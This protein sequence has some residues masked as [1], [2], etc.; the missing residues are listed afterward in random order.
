MPGYTYFHAFQIKIRSRSVLSTGI[1]IVNA[2]QALK[3]L[4]DKLFKNVKQHL[5]NQCKTNRLKQRKLAKGML[6][7]PDQQMQDNSVEACLVQNILHNLNNSKSPRWHYLLS[8]GI[9]MC[10]QTDKTSTC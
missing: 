6:L 3:Y 5:T 7:V 4:T 1:P 9:K 8:T 2:K 10:R